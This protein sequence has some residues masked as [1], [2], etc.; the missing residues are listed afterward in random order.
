M[1]NRVALALGCVLAVSGQTP[2]PRIPELLSR[3]A[4]ITLALNAAP[5]HL[6][7]AATV[8]VLESKGYVVARKGSNGFTCLV[9]RD[10]PLNQKPTCW[11]REGSET[12]VPAVLREGEL[13]MQGKPV[14]EIRADV[15]RGF[16]SGKFIAPRRPGI[17]YMLS[18]NRNY[19]P[20]TGKVDIFPP[21]VMF[22]APNLTD[23]D[24]GST[25][26]PSNGLPFIAYQ[27]PH[28]YMIMLADGEK[29]H[30]H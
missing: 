17:A 11:D 1:T 16:E 23:A 26:D 4:E 7:D 21:H 12:I 20:G 2:P 15:R 8:Y 24:I 10:H 30:Q 28:G 13:L 6:R 22:Y 29:Q 5:A 9:H 14:P 18:V 19:N 25:G 3:D 27:G